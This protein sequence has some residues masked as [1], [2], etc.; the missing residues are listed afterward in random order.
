MHS[1]A[2]QTVFAPCARCLPTRRRISS[3]KI[4]RYMN[5]RHQEKSPPT[6]WSGAKGTI[7]LPLSLKGC[8][9]V[10]LPLGYKLVNDGLII[11]PHRCLCQLLGHFRQLFTYARRQLGLADT[12]EKKPRGAGAHAGRNLEGDPNPNPFG[13]LSHMLRLSPGPNELEECMNAKGHEQKNR[14]MHLTRQIE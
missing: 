1:R 4:H 10:C 11:M 3:E 7:T 13:R 9:H 14:H 12:D 5:F 2:Q 8:R 6:M